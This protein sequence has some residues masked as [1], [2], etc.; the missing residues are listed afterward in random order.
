MLC[1]YKELLAAS[2]WSFDI[3]MFYNTWFRVTDSASHQLSVRRKKEKKI[4]DN[5]LAYEHPSPALEKTISILQTFQEVLATFTSSRIS[6]FDP[7]N[8]CLCWDWR[9]KTLCESDARRLQ[10]SFQFFLDI[11]SA[12]SEIFL[13]E[14]VDL[15]LSFSNAKTTYRTRNISPTCV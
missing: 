7:I 11:E 10:L 12:N 14:N 15:I 4:S 9:V 1:Q 8:F 2:C 3:L 5:T 6:V 13:T